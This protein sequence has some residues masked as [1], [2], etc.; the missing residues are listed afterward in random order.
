MSSLGRR[1]QRRTAAVAR[2]AFA[3]I[4]LLLV[5]VREA[6]AADVDWADARAHDKGC[7]GTAHIFHVR[8]EHP[9]GSWSTECA[10]MPNGL[11][12][13]IKMAGDPVRL[14]DKAWTEVTILDGTCEPLPT[15]TAKGR[16]GQECDDLLKSAVLNGFETAGNSGEGSEAAV[17]ILACHAACEATRFA[18]LGS[19]NW[20]EKWA[21]TRECEGVNRVYHI[22][23]RD[24]DG[25]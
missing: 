19:L 21:V 25:L 15:D 20:Y 22:P 9:D 8:C 4:A 2:V 13:G 12:R 23:C 6:R 24:G 18:D 3:L 7:R 1:T 11:F 14:P 5:S 16:C 10:D 17:V